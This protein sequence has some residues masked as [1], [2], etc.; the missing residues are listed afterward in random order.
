MVKRVGRGEVPSHARVEAPKKAKKEAKTLAELRAD[1]KRISKI[2]LG[3]LPV[4]VAFSAQKEAPESH[5]T[6]KAKTIGSRKMVD[7]DR[8]P[9]PST[10]GR[11]F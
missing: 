6:R 4:G 11:S 9:L 2:A 7:R 1:A 3:N 8:N 5:A 10:K